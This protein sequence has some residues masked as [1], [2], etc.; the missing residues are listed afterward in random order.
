MAARTARRHGG[1][2]SV[3]APDRGS[4]SST[5]VISYFRPIAAADHIEAIVD[6]AHEGVVARN[7]HGARACSSDRW[8]YRRR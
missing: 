5:V 7:H 1:P 4:N 2:R 8:S 6:D 3:Q